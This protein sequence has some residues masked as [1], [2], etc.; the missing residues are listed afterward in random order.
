M[1]SNKSVKTITNFSAIHYSDLLSWDVKSYLSLSN[2][3]NKKYPL[4]LFGTFLKKPTI[5]KI[6]IN[7]KEEYKIL[8]VRSYGKG[9]YIN[10]I[11]KGRTLKMREYQQAKVNHLFWCKVDTKNGSFGIITDDL[12]NGVASSN[13]T[14]AEIDTNTIRV[15]FLQ[16]LF[17]D[18]GVMSYLDSF[19]TGSTNRKYI[20]QD[21]LLNEI[22]IPLPSLKEQ[23]HII[24]AYNEKIEIAKKLEK[25][26][27]ELEKGIEKYL[28]EKLGIEKAIKS[29]K[30]SGLYFFSFQDITEWG[31]DKIKTI[32]KGNKS[33][34]KNYT[35]SKLAIKVFRGKSPVYKNKSSSFILNQKCNRWNSLDVSFAKNVDDKWFSSIDD[36]FFTREG[37][38]LI[39]STGEGTIGRATYI[40]NGYQGLLYDSHM[41]L[42]RINTNK[43][44][45]ELFVEL[46]NSQFGQD[47]VN[48]LK[49]AQATKQTELGVNNLNR[50]VMPIPDILEFQKDII[51]K[52][53]SDRTAISN[54]KSKAAINIKLAQKEFEKEIFG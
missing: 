14:F 9:A 40:K 34:F 49:S 35:I 2:E 20:R 46:F 7:D 33:E 1:E 12:A 4:V 38:I 54:L 26:A 16:L 48:E 17:S 24:K 23:E 11:V 29:D 39:N 41:L 44:N 50:V 45:P 6:K 25:E 31:V 19:V 27:E 42:L 32:N 28:F 30:I 21:Q 10:R 37:D 22:K 53:K 5:N 52:I 8:G 13:M 15:D 47:Q 51:K 43:M 36:S 3:F 18:K